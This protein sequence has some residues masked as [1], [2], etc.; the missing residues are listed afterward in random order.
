MTMGTAIAMKMEIVTELYIF[1]KLD[2]NYI[3]G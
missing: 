2:S 3:C 1:E